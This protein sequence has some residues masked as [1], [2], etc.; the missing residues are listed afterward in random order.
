MAII[1]EEF[2]RLRREQGVLARRDERDPMPAVVRTLPEDL[3]QVMERHGN[4]PEALPGLNVDL[5]EILTRVNPR[6]ERLEAVANAQTT[7]TQVVQDKTVF[8]LREERSRKSNSRRRKKRKSQ[9]DTSDDSS[10]SKDE[11]SS[12]DDSDSSNT[13]TENASDD[14]HRGPGSRKKNKSSWLLRKKDPK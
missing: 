9:P 6:L 2:E 7:A 1:T 4:A 10:G 3:N 11:D 8:S 13:S 14:D 5:E 12:A